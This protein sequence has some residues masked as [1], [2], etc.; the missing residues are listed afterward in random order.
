MKAVWTEILFKIKK[1][2]KI[3]AVSIYF[4]FSGVLD[5]S[6]TLHELN[7]AFYFG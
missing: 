6:R 2:K 3:D 4:F 5:E 1:K 7:F